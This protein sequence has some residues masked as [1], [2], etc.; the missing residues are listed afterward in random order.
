[1]STNK[2]FWRVLAKFMNSMGREEGLGVYMDYIP[3]LAKGT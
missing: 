1:M 2:M 3:Q